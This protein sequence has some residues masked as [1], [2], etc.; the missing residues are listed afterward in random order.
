M[1]VITPLNAALSL[2]EVPPVR[3][4]L[5][6]LSSMDLLAFSASTM[7]RGLRLGCNGRY[8]LGFFNGIDGIVERPKQFSIKDHLFGLFLGFRFIP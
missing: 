7:F 2:V 8:L 4:G 5:N 1:R 3:R 6:E